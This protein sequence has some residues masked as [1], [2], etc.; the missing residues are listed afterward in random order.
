ML[1]VQIYG[2]DLMVKAD[3]IESGFDAFIIARR[4]GEGPA[5]NEALPE[6]IEALRDH[7]RFARPEACVAIAA[8]RVR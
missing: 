7:P 1:R 6:A 3:V 8:E 2:P 4:V 5:R